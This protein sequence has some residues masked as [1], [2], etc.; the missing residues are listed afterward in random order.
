MTLFNY[1]F[2]FCIKCTISRKKTAPIKSRLD[3]RI[4]LEAY[5]IIL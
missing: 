4:A 1:D 5:Y 3:S 2:L